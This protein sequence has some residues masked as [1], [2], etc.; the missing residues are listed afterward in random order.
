[1]AFSPGKDRYGRDPLAW[2]YRR[3]KA[4]VPFPAAPR[5]Y[6]IHPFPRPQRRA[7]PP[8]IPDLPLRELAGAG[9][10]FHGFFAVAHLVIRASRPEPGPTIVSLSI[11]W[12]ETNHL[13][14]VGDGLVIVS[15]AFPVERPA[16]I[17]RGIVRVDPDR[18]VEVGDGH[19]VI[20]FA[21]PDDA[22]IVVCLGEIGIDPDHLVEVGDGL[23][24]L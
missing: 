16:Q 19:A 14:I 22:A 23:V 15:L 13:V 17:R 10:G 8:E 9:R 2:P 20:Q 24:V 18:L 4:P 5:P 11:F 7:Y 1:M 12:I 6:R 21:P 3:C